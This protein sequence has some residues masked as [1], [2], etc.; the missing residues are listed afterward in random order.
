MHL[1]MITGK[2]LDSTLYHLR[3]LEK[4]GVVTH[5][6]DEGHVMRWERNPVV[7]E[8]VPF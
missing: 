5:W 2:T 4:C 7:D 1:A 6:V 8:M 3:E